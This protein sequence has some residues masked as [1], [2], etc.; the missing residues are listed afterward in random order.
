M[1]AALPPD[2]RNPPPSQNRGCVIVLFA[3]LG[4]I[5]VFIGWAALAPKAPPDPR[6][7]RA[8]AELL[9]ETQIKDGVWASDSSLWVAVL[10]NGTNRNGYAAYVC[11]VVRAHGLREFTVRVQDAAAL[12]RDELVTLGSH[13]CK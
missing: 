1:V 11:G 12:L 13:F 3:F 6:R 5:S 2:N 9:K 8:L 7:A 4:L 10:D